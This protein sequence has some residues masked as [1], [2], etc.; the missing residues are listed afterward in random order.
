MTPDVPSNYG[1]YL[2]TQFENWDNFSVKLILVF[3][4]Y[5]DWKI[6]PNSKILPMVGY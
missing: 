5:V 2:K 6:L 3:D 4:L 1:K